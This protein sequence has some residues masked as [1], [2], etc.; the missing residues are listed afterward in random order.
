MEKTQNY[1][2][3]CF[4]CS[5]AHIMCDEDEVISDDGR[6]SYHVSCVG[7]TPQV[8]EYVDNREVI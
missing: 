8:F 4:G 3:V 1:P 2:K 6:K 5:L 7:K